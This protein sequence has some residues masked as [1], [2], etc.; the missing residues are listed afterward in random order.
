MFITLNL[1]SLLAVIIFAALAGAW[2]WRKATNVWADYTSG[3]SSS[4]EQ[5]LR[6]Y[7]V[8]GTNFRLSPQPQ[9]IDGQ[10]VFTFCVAPL[11]DPSDGTEFEVRGNTLKQLN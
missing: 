2:V 1:T 3:G 4:F 8:S 7:Y 9:K 5:Y 11:A 10:W 6:H